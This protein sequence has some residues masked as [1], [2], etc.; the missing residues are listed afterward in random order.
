MVI[1]TRRI[2]LVATPASNQPAVQA[3]VRAEGEQVQPTGPVVEELVQLI[4]LAVE[5]VQLTGPV[6][7]GLVQLIALVVEPEPL[8]VRAAEPE[9]GV[10]R[11]VAR[12]SVLAAAEPAP[13]RPR[14]RLVVAQI[15]LATK[16]SGAVP[17]AEA[18][19]VPASAPAAEALAA[20]AVA[21]PRAQ[22]V[23][24]ADI[25]WAAAG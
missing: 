5:Q 12:G 11:V 4:A 24:G 6:V 2:V 18:A 23:I 20:A 8:L 19:A 22:V 14:D 16:I 1:E 7:V 13:C 3:I 15:A 10:V 21:A 17:A 9:L 25:A